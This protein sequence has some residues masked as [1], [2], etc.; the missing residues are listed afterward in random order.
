L[1]IN[2]RVKATRQF[3][4]KLFVSITIYHESGI[5]VATLDNLFVERPFYLAGTCLEISCAVRKFNL[6]PGGYYCSLW[7]S[8]G[9]ETFQRIEHAFKFEVFPTNYLGTAKNHTAGRHGLIYFDQEWS[10]S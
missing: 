1:K 5:K 10:G 8:D 7:S 6:N 4:G 2:L 9:F 3:N